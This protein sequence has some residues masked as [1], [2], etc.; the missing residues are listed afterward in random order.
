MPEIFKA[1]TRIYA[2]LIHFALELGSYIAIAMYLA[3][4]AHK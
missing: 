2:A 4:Y 3:T 1:D